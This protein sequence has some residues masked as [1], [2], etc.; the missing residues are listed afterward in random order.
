MA[1]W[2]DVLTRITPFPIC[3]EVGQALPGVYGWVGLCG[4][5]ALVMLFAPVRRA[6]VDGLLPW[7]LPEDLDHLRR[8]WFRLLRLSVCHFHADPELGGPGAK[9]DRFVAAVDLAK[10]E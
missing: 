7:A 2:S 3:A 1:F 6:L 8:T 5:Y 4:G 9:P 10:G